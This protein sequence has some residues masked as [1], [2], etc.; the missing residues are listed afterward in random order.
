MIKIYCYDIAEGTLTRPTIEELP[1]ILERDNVDVWVDLEAPTVAEAEILTTVFDFHELAVEDCTAVEYE[2]AKLD[3]YENYLFLV[4]H[5]VFFSS[6]AMTFDIV[7]LN[8]FFG[9]HYV[10][11]YHTT[12]T[13]GINHLRRRLK[14]DIDF[15]GR[16][17]D[18]ILHA[19]V[20]SLVDNYILNFKELERTIYGI[21]TEIL[22]D[23]KKETFGFLFTLKRNLV[24]LKRVMTP[25]VEMIGEL[26][27]TEHELIQEENTVYFHDVHDH[28]STI[29]GRL[30]SYIETVTGTMD[31]YVSL[32]Q[33]RMNT[34]M[35]TLTVI[36]TIVLV[37]T[38]VASIYGMNLDLPFGES[39]HG[40]FVIMGLCAV[41]VT[42]M[43]WFFKKKD[44]F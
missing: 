33:Y 9:K 2:E 43:L 15:M 16:G 20:D 19:I 31:T 14:K 26:S 22:T 38:L 34:V 28:V 29:D 21:E 35:Q 37:P 5:S 11:T 44:M 17:T 1:E 3:D 27:S 42:F 12:P 8:L 40:F 41:M 10:V 7:E 25:M 36:A 4:T 39:P 24:N 23:P 13:P 18:E 30:Q 32:S 6:E